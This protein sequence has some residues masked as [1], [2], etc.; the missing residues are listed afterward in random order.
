MKDYCKKAAAAGAALLMLVSLTACTDAVALEDAEGTARTV[1]SGAPE[2]A[3]ADVAIAVEDATAVELKDGA[4]QTASGISVNGDVVTVTKAGNYAFSGTLS[5]GQIVVD[6]AG[7]DITLTLCGVNIASSSGTPL[8]VK[9]AANVSLV[10]ADGASNVLNGAARAGASGD[11][12]GAVLFS[13]T[14]L[15]IDGGGKLTVNGVF[16]SGIY[17]KGMLEINGGIL[18]VSAAKNGLAGGDHVTVG[19]GETTVLAGGDAIRSGSGGTGGDVTISAGA[20]NLEAQGNGIRSM[21]MVRITGGNIRIY[22]GGEGN[23]ST[24]DTQEASSGIDGES[25][26][27]TGVSGRNGI[28]STVGTIISGGTVTVNS[29]GD[30]VRTDGSVVVSGGTYTLAAGNGGIRAQEQLTI[31]DC[32]LLKVDA[33]VKGLEAYNISISGGEISIRSSGAGIA[34]AGP[35]MSSAV[36]AENSSSGGTGAGGGGVLTVSGGK[37]HVDSGADGIASKG[38]VRISGGAVVV[39]GPENS[40]SSA[41]NCED[42]YTIEGGT[43]VAAGIAGTKEAPSES[44]KQNVISMTFDAAVS[45][46]SE[47]ILADS[48][49]KTVFTY[50]PVKSL[51]NIVFSSAA[52][53]KSNTYSI[54]VNGQSVVTFAASDGETYVN[55]SG[56]TAEEQ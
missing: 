54:L 31:E 29:A 32:E 25:D 50:T 55:N 13:E 27:D 39:D 14:D 10:L 41:L 7:K 3:S 42:G 35:G 21:G 8:S 9:D 15:A 2:Q 12:S 48:A 18:A 52:I 46:G 49:G 51:R 24:A 38:S 33:A 6:A 53:L 4:T 36:Q 5:D 17:A 23:S 56:V 43:L 37:L 30:A 1:A 40:G 11:E 47:V 34:V 45:A 44:S 22:S 20:V 28:Y 26:P 19:S 16:N